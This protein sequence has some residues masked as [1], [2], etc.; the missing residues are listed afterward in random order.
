MDHNYINSIWKMFLIVECD[1]CYYK[2]SMN[3]EKECESVC[4]DATCIKCFDK[5]KNCISECDAN[6]LSCDKE[7]SMC[8]CYVLLLVEI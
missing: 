4:N 6:R 2:C 8:I 3:C 5:N 1:K 7:C